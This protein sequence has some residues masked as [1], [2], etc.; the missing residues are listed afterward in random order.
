MSIG[1]SRGTSA[2]PH[3]RFYAGDWF[4]GVVGLK[5][6]ERGVYISMCVYIWTAGRRVP[7]DD[8]EAAR[9]LCLQFNLYQRVRNR[10]LTLGKITYNDDGY[11]NQRAE[12]ELDYAR[13]ARSEA[14]QDIRSGQPSDAAPARDGRIELLAEGSREQGGTQAHSSDGPEANARAQAVDPVLAASAPAG[15]GPCTQ[16]GT[17]VGTQA[18]TLA[19]AYQGALAGDAEK[20]VANQGPSK[21]PRTR[22]QK[23]EE[24]VSETHAG[25]GVF[26][27]CETIRHHAFVISLPAIRLG[28]QASGLDA[29]AIKTH[30]IAHAL[31]WAAEIEAGKLSDTVVPSKIANFLSASIMGATNRKAAAETRKARA[32]TAD[33]P[34]SRAERARA[35][36]DQ[37][38][39]KRETAGATQ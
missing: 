19:G 6:D 31:Q 25:H 10:L 2:P 21:E 26:V 3:V 5:A 30:C 37:M 23:E 24:C 15:A 8:A 27:N 1:R 22:N 36:M 35:L 32:G 18:G 11:G 17:L 34:L 14:C 4:T 7:I 20:T 13:N 16:A 39:K 12:A 33:K 9:R 38:A 28:T 29:E